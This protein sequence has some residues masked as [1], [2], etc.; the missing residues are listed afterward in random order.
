MKLTC[1]ITYKKKKARTNRLTRSVDKVAS[2]LVRSNEKLTQQHEKL[3]RLSITG[4]QP[5]QSDTTE[6]E[7][8]KHQP[9]SNDIDPNVSHY[10]GAAD[11]QTTSPTQAPLSDEKKCHPEERTDASTSKQEETDADPVS[12]DDTL[13]HEKNKDSDPTSQHIESDLDGKATAENASR[14][15][16]DHDDSQG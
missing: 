3:Q 8:Q 15:S 9:S 7:D 4:L 11:Q 1:I 16:G 6:Q 14:S 2:N 12:N 13:T 10:D 5:P